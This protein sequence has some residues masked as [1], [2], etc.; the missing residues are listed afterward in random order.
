LFEFPDVLDCFAVNWDKHLIVCGLHGEKTP[1]I[2][3]FKYPEKLLVA[4][5]SGEIKLSTVF[6]SKCLSSHDTTVFLPLVFYGDVPNHTGFL[7][8]ATD[9]VSFN[10]GLEKESVP[11]AKMEC[12]FSSLRLSLGL[13]MHSFV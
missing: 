10:V 3:M 4:T 9:F 12:I 8:S 5:L 11:K 7:H 2:M 13:C 1:K 6:F